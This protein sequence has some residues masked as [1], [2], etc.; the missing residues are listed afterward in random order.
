MR[1]A[2]RL[3][4]IVHLLRARP[5][6]TAA[7]L[8]VE[9]EVSERTIY[10]DVQDL[11]R[12]GVPIRGEAGVG[13][14]LPPSFDLPPLMFTAEEVEALVVGTRIVAAWGDAG[15]ARSA[16]AAL[17]KAT[18][19]LPEDLRAK[20]SAVDVHVPDFHV[21]ARPLA[22]MQPLRAAIAARKKV[23]FGYRDRHERES[24]RV[25]R[26]LGLFFWGAAWTVA[27]WCE[28][29]QDFRSFRLDRLERLEPLDETFADEPGRDLASF[30]RAARADD[31]MR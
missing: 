26:P 15:L 5:T 22:A 2:D 29:R 20:L 13:Y 4:Q 28:L 8:A 25:L 1:R 24:D 23:R 17:A 21:P 3:F 11:I 7:A 10:R 30:L 16:R 6:T 18:S 9:L 12:S 27:G 19:V 14:A 31:G